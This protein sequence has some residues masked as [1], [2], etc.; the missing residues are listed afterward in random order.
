MHSS[1]SLVCAPPMKLSSH[2]TNIKSSFVLLRTLSVTC[3]QIVVE[4]DCPTVGEK[5]VPIGSTLNARCQNIP[6]HF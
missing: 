5:Y 4:I 3:M 1:V 2:G 6:R